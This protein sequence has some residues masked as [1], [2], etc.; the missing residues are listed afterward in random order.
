MAAVIGRSFSLRLLEELE[1]N[2]PDTVLDAIEEAERADLVIPEP[3]RRDTRYRFVHELVRQTLAESLSL[4]R[5]Q[6]LHMRIADAIERVYS[7]NPESQAPSLAHHLYQAGTMADR[8]RTTGYLLMAAKHA[9]TG[10]AHEEALGHLDRAI[11][12]WEGETSLSVAELMNDR[13]NTLRNMGRTEEAVTGYHQAIDLF[14]ATGAISRIAEPSLALSYLLA[15]RNPDSASEIMERIHQ[16]M[17]GRTY[18]QSSVLSMRAA[19]MSISGEP[20]V[21]D[22]MFDEVRALHRL[23]WKTPP[24][25]PSLLFEAIHYYQSFQINKVAAT[26]SRLASACRAAGDSWNASLIE[27][28]GPWADLYG[29]RPREGACALRLPDFASGK[30]RQLWGGV[31]PQNRRLDCECR[32]RRPRGSRQ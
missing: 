26:T 2:E 21:A 3:E 23:N 19:I 1:N 7:A 29:G 22:R 32:T 11:S 24:Q 13:A 16:R 8:E 28:Y 12:L 30:N 31:G 18:L 10:S 6:R 4:P 15:W 27:Y 14:E 20:V 17:A 25:G 9:R 5:R